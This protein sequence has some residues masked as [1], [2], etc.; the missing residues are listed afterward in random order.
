MLATLLEVLGF[1]LVV[2]GAALVSPPLAFVTAGMLLIVAALALDST[3]RKA[4]P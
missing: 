3:R 2:T 1:T 4:S